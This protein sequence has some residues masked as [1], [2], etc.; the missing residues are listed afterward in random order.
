[1]NKDVAFREEVFPF[2]KNTSLST[3]ESSGS[4]D[5]THPTPSIS[6][7]SNSDY[8]IPVDI[9]TIDL[10]PDNLSLGDGSS[11]S[12]PFICDDNIQV[13]NLVPSLES[14]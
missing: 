8:S 12:N 11:A 13:E 2:Q 5:G 4:Q 14:S 10:D 6:T 1:M 7:T 9:Y 3:S